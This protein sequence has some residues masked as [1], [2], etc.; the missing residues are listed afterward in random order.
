MLAMSVSP[1][2]GGTTL[3]DRVVARGGAWTKVTSVCQWLAVP[4]SLSTGST[5]GAPSTDATVG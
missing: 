5:L 2:W 4:R 1:P 3:L